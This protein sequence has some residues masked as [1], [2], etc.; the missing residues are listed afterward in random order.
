MQG[1]DVA[2][3]KAVIDLADLNDSGA[4]CAA[5]WRKS[6]GS[7]EAVP[8]RT[9]RHQQAEDHAD[10]QVDQ[11][12]QRLDG[13]AAEYCKNDFCHVRLSFGFGIQIAVRASC[14]Q[15]HFPPRTAL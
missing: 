11:G 1:R 15:S 5:S 6:A 8:L 9:V 3:L 2:Y 12:E 4:A 7:S 10:Q 14:P 13:F